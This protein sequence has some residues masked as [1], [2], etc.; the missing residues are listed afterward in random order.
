MKRQTDGDAMRIHVSN[1]KG[2]TDGRAAQSAVPATTTRRNR[3]P[4]TVAKAYILPSEVRDA[5]E[6][7]VAIVHTTKRGSITRVDYVRR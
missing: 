6:G 7:Y 4:R 2:S 1:V 3:K 5:P